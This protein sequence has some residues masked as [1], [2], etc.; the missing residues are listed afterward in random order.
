MF[1]GKERRK[2]PRTE[3]TC[4]VKFQVQPR[5]VDDV[6]SSW[7]IASAQNISGGGILFNY[8][9]TISPD[10]ILG[11]Y[12]RFPE[13]TEPFDCTGQVVRVDESPV[14][15]RVRI[16]AVFTH[17]DGTNQKRILTAIKGKISE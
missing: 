8:D 17:I 3:T 5:E 11:M 13:F 6:F 16:A 12:I 2:N 9:K 15:S 10:S 1:K 14:S 4:L 7:D